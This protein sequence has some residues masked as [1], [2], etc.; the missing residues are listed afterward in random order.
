MSHLSY[1]FRFLTGLIAV[2][3]LTQ[4]CIRTTSPE[5]IAAE[6]GGGYS[7][8]GKLRP[9]GYVQDVI[10]VDSCAYLAQGQGGFAIVN[11]KD[12]QQPQLMS[13]LLY[14]TSGYARKL[15]YVKDSAGTEVI[16]CADGAYGVASIDVT[17][18]LHPR[19]PKRNLGYKPAISFFVFKRF[20]FTMVNGGGIA[21]APFDDA[22]YPGVEVYIKVPGYGKSVCM[23]SDSVYALLAIGEGGVVMLNFSHLVTGTEI[24]DSLSGRLDLPGSAEYIVIIPGTKYACIAC[25]PAGLQIIDYSDTAN[26]K[27]AGAFATGGFAKDVCVA[28]NRA[29]LATELHGVQIIDI[30]NVASPRLIG[31]VQINDV[32]GIDVNNGYVYAADQYEGLVIIKIP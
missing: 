27:V 17:D 32:R 23:S 1:Y 20:L 18:K 28:G 3:A 26:I 19:V 13:E 15:A 9:T 21:I 16:Y 11:I 4:S 7:V 25:G 22:K 8:V 12:P 24:P 14:E 10:V 6:E 2:G 30:S 5:D 31:K 29:Y